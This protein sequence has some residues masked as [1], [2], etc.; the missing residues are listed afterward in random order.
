MLYLPEK[1]SLLARVKERGF[2]GAFLGRLVLVTMAGWIYLLGSSFLKCVF[3]VFLEREIFDDEMGVD[4]LGGGGCTKI[5]TGEQSFGVG[6]HD[7]VTTR[8]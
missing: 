3:G 4:D 2:S 7:I 8:E 1:L 5:S 6:H